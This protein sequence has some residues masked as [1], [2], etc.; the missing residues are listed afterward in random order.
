MIGVPDFIDETGVWQVP[1]T[2]IPGTG[3]YA[4]VL[5]VAKLQHNVVL[6]MDFEPFWQITHL[7]VQREY[8]M[9]LS[10]TFCDLFMQRHFFN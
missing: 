1:S 4:V 7:V 3:T 2:V 6:G 8:Q 10:S 9:E 5:F